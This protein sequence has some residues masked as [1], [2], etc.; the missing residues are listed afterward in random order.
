MLYF[1]FQKECEND[2]TDC[3]PEEKCNDGV[4]IKIPTE[5]PTETT[6]S[7]PP[8]ESTTP[9]SSTESPGRM[10]LCNLILFRHNKSIMHLLKWENVIKS[11]V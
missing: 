10:S 7:K 6:T 3:G 1:L 5:P 4:C 2:S 11:Q 9:E 8:T